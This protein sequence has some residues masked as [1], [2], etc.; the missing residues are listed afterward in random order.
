MAFSAAAIAS[1]PIE[2]G[3]GL[4][5]NNIEDV[6]IQLFVKL[7]GDTT[8]SITPVRLT[9]VRAAY[10][11]FIDGT[12]SAT[13]VPVYINTIGAVSVTFTVMETGANTINGTV[14]LVGTK[15]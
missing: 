4:R 9:N 11:Y 14:V 1:A 5:L 2:T 10:F 8:G 12:V 6:E 3:R 7:T 13:V 15:Q